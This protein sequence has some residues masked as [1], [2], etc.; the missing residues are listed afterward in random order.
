MTQN[1]LTKTELAKILKNPEDYAKKI[2]IPKLVAWLKLFSKYYYLKPSALVDDEVYDKMFEILEKRDPKNN[3]L[4][5]TGSNEKT[6]NM[7]ELSYPMPSLKKIKESDDDRVLERWIESYPGPY[8]IS[9]K[10]DGMSGLLIIKDGKKVLYTKGSEKNG[11][12][13]SHL[14]KYLIINIDPELKNCAVRGE[15]VLSNKNFEVMEHEYKNKRN[16]IQ[17]LLYGKKSKVEYIKLVDFVAY[18]LFTPVM[19]KSQQLVKLKKYGF[20]IPKSTISNKITKSFLNSKLSQRKKDSEYPIDGIV[21][22]DNSKKYK[23][24]V[25]APKHAFA[26]KK[27]F[28]YQQATTIIKKI[29][30]NKSMYGYL[31]PRIKIEPV[32]I[33]D[34]KISYVT[35][36]NAKYVYDNNL[37]VGAKIVIIRSGDVIPKIHK[38]IVPAK[39]P[40]FPNCD[41]YWDEN[42][43]NII[44]DE[45]D[46]LGVKVKKLT[47]FFKELEVK[48]LSEETMRK[49]VGYGLEDIIDVLEFKISDLSSVAGL[50]T[51]LLKKIRKNIDEAIKKAPVEKYA[52]GSMIFGRGFGSKRIK[53]ILEKIPNIFEVKHIK[54]ELKE[55][56]LDIP[57]FDEIT[58]SQFI[59]GYDEFSFFYNKLKEKG[60]ITVNNKKKK[61][62]KSSLNGKSIV[63]TGF[64]DPK[65]KD[66]IENRGGQVKTSVSKNTNILVYSGLCSDNDKYKKA[67]ELGVTV[68]SKSEFV[69]KYLS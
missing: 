44:S 40:D 27:L 26:Y 6:E 1:K 50:G 34:V 21:I 60:L 49:F 2:D 7:V 48:F 28:D 18:E 54:E 58:A 36:H 17:G 25:D 41:Y 4:S 31:I 15:L 10:L 11:A 13:I 47:H 59:S 63:M 55:K 23:Y 24:T 65:I 67:I 33:S 8:I 32:T 35:G 12:D 9:D 3:Y 16:A 20:K 42:E 68:M 57:G 38:V 39:K 37:G 66:E 53:L 51:T 62:K 14:I 5:Q 69:K 19:K 52:S 43:V 45:D 29:E 61:I 64:R 46:D 22:F 30:W 56:I